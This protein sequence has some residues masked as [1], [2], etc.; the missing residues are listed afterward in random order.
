M[1][2]LLFFKKH[3]RLSLFLATHIIGVSLWNMANAFADLSWSEFTA[4]LWCGA[5]LVG[6]MIFIVFYIIFLEQF[7]TSR[8]FKNYFT[9][10]FILFPALFFS[11]IAFSSIYITE[12]KITGVTPAITVPGKVNYLILA[13]SVGI[14]FYGLGRL[15]NAY[16]SLPLIKQQQ[17]FYIKIGFLV[18]LSAGIIFT[19]ILPLL[20]NFMLFS[21][22]AQFTIISIFLTIYVI[23][24]HRFLDIKVVVQRG[25]IFSILSGSVV[26]FYLAFLFLVQS[27]LFRSDQVAYL[28]SAI[29]VCLMGIFFVPKIDSFLRRV[30]NKFFF[31]D[32]YNAA[33]VL[34][35][36]S[37]ALNSSL[38]LSDI[39][40]KTSDLLESNLKIKKVYINLL[41][42]DQEKSKEELKKKSENY[43]S[44]LVVPLAKGRRLIGAMFLGAKL[45][46]DSYTSEDLALL[47]TFAH[48]MTLALEKS[49]LYEEVKDYSKNLEIKIAERITEIKNLQERQSQ[50]LFEIAHELQTPLTILKGELGALTMSSKEKEKVEILEKNIDRVSRFISSLL[51][52]ARLDF[53]E[54][55][56]MEKVNFSQLLNSLV[57]EFLVIAQESNIVFKS[58]ITNNVFVTGDKNKLVELVGNLVSNA[59]KYISNERVVVVSLCRAGQQASLKIVDT[60][61]GIP[62]EDLPNLFQKFYRGHRLVGSGTGLGLAICKKIITLHNGQVS[63]K[64]QLGK[65]TVAEVFLPI[66]E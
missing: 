3:D 40:L 47:N 48:Q 29:A 16:L 51:R 64:S 49:Q 21:L 6:S 50:E 12:I 17:I 30:T 53:A 37:E 59:M 19:I 20:G 38:N 9:S 62:L 7:L 44:V 24:R 31:K 4:R 26:L 33:E 25:L 39:I 22:A 32:G 55:C 56:N 10:F 60:G 36:L 63:I 8:I 34:G 46:G 23:Y 65:G 11:A 13:Y 2:I 1:A 27:I 14:I 28:V 41:S 52:L 57:E 58:N 45:S 54:E 61:I 43:L 15:R 42:A 35:L 66:T 5:A 18:N